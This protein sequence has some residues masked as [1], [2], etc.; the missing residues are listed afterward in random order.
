MSGQPRE[1]K[2]QARERLAAERTAQAAA[3]RRRERI[4]RIALFGVVVAIVIAVVVVVVINSNRVDTSGANPAGTDDTYGVVV[5]DGPVRVDVYEDFQCPACATFEQQGG[6]EALAELATSGAA[7]VVYYPLSF[8]D[9]NL[10]NDSSSR[11]ANASGCAVDE[12]GTDAFV[13]FHNAVFANQP[14][15]EGTGFTDDQLARLRRRR[16]GYRRRLRRLRRG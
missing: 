2:R 9:G 4:Q 8:L 13:D 6:G 7:T 12:G 14:E 16:R 3:Q 1:S 5:G 10:G 11:A 15:E